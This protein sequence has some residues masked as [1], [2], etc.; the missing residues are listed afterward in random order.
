PMTRVKEGNASRMLP[1]RLEKFCDDRKII[2][3][4]AQITRCCADFSVS[5]FGYLLASAPVTCG[6]Q[7]RS[8]NLAPK[9]HMDEGITP[10][11]GN[12]L[13][14]SVL[15]S[16]LWLFVRLSVRSFGVAYAAR[17]L[18]SPDA[19]RLSTAAV[20]E[21]VLPG[22]PLTDML[23]DHRTVTASCPN[24]QINAMGGAGC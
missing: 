8:P 6:R 21:R 9:C 17:D 14:N 5:H 7:H 24:A 3:E 16:E 11:R 15:Q 22:R 18:V 4:S 20:C 13:R 12:R 2:V 1:K 19:G 10:I 23:A